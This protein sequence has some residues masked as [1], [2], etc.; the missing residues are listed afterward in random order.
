MKTNTV[1]PDRKSARLPGYD[2]SL[3]GA[4]FITV[5]TYR[6]EYLFGN[7]VEGQLHISRYGQ[8]VAEAWMD[9]TSHYPHTNLGKFVVMPNHVHGIV[10]ITQDDNNFRGLSKNLPSNGFSTE[11]KMIPYGLPE[12]VRGFK[13]FSARRINNLRKLRGNPVWQ[14]SYYDRII[15]NER[16]LKDIGEYI[17]SNPRN[18]LGD[19]LRNSNIDA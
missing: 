2:Y 4:Y 10:I 5:V 1:K 7:V 11:K 12:I 18:W 6:R 13:S 9:L 19:Q 3:P 16:E 14:R 8:L 17:Q 15:R